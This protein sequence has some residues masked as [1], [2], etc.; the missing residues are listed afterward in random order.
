MSLLLGKLSG[1]EGIPMIRVTRPNSAVKIPSYW[2]KRRC[3]ETINLN[4]QNSS[5]TDQYED[6]RPTSKVPISS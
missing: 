2:Y 6:P 3:D 4:E 1:L 5:V